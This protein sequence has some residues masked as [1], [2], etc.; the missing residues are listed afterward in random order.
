MEV[1]PMLVS[2][3]HNTGHRDDSA[4][5]YVILLQPFE[6]NY[7]KLHNREVKNDGYT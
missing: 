3:I 7:C 5:F 1:S 2:G 4:R 6:R